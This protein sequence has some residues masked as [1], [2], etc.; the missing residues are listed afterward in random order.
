MQENAALV[1]FVDATKR[2]VCIQAASADDRFD[3]RELNIDKEQQCLVCNSSYSSS[4][5]FELTGSGIGD[6]WL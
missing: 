1:L 3:M 5:C 4:Q 2:T 6:A